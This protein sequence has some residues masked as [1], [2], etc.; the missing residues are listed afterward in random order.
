MRLSVRLMLLGISGPLVSLAIFLALATIGSIRLAQKARIEISTMFDHDNLSSLAVTTSIIQKSAAEFSRDIQQ[1]SQELAGSL[2]PLRVDAKGR[3]SWRGAPLSV[4]QAPALLNERLRLPLAMPHERA[5]L[6]VRERPGVWRRL[7]GIT[8]RGKALR[9]GTLARPSTVA[10]FENL[11]KGAPATEVGRNTL[12]QLD[13]EWR[14]AR[15]TLLSGGKPGDGHLALMVDVST[16]AA[17]Q[18]LAAGSSLFPIDTHQAA[19]FGISPTGTLYC[20]YQTPDTQACIDL[21]MA[22]R[23][24]GG[25][26]EPRALGQS[27]TFERKAMVRPPGTDTP[28]LQHLYIATFPEWNWLAVVSV[29]EEAL[30]DALVPMQEAKDQMVRRLVILTLILISASGVAAWLIARGIRRE[31]RELAA[32][33]DAIADGKDHQALTYPADDAIGRL[34]RAFNRMSGAV[35]DRENSLR[36]QIRQMEININASELQGQVCSI[37][38]DPGFEQLSARARAMRQRRLEQISASGPSASA[39]AGSAGDCPPPGE[40]RDRAAPAGR[41]SG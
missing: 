4:D 8:S 37:L 13:G 28:V 25:I 26:P 18:L 35:A 11:F 15:L 12:I 22:M 29:E 36:D 1:D 10:D 33:A 2:A 41:S 31:L 21:A 24:N 39:D 30:A 17:S 14:M 19:F 32:A 40:G 20:S 23:E 9:P 34:V 16:Q 3:L 38:N 5:S 7:T 6:Y 27:R